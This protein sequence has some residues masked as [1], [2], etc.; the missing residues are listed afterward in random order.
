MLV[1]RIRHNQALH[2]CRGPLFQVQYMS[3]R[4]T[5]PSAKAAHFLRETLREEIEARAV[6]L[7]WGDASHRV[8][9]V[10]PSTI[11]AG[12]DEVLFCELESRAARSEAFLQHYVLY[13]TRFRPQ[14]PDNTLT[15]NYLNCRPRSW[16]PRTSVRAMVALQRK[17]TALG[18]TSS[19]YDS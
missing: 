14:V 1:A 2:E 16:L 9:G 3:V 18:F 7:R 17:N 11:F 15:H 12:Q 5:L 6:D 4:W 13:P 8:V 10:A 19:I